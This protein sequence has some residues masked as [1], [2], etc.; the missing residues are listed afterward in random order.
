MPIDP[1]YM[2]TMILM[3]VVILMLI[4]SNADDAYMY[5]L[6]CRVCT[7]SIICLS[8]P[9][10]VCRLFKRSHQQPVYLYHLIQLVQL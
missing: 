2:L 7:F 4:G 10:A 6:T 5:N 9:E 8:M 1:L 3:V